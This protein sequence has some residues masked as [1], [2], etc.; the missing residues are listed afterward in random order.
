MRYE[1]VVISANSPGVGS[2]PAAVLLRSVTDDH[3]ETGV[4]EDIREV[5]G[6]ESAEIVIGSVGMFM[7][8]GATIGGAALFAE[9]EDTLSNFLT[10]SSRSIVSGDPKALVSALSSE[11]FSR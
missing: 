7:E 6:G 10:I 9:L 1:Y 8:R 4:R 2:I 11:H 3:L 5:L